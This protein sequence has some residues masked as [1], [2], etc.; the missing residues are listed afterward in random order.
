[1]MRVDHVGVR[2][3]PFFSFNDI[4]DT[5]TEP[6]TMYLAREFSQRGIAY[7]HIAEPGWV[8]GPALSDD[9]RRKLRAAYAGVLIC[10][11][12]YT[13]QSGEKLLA[14]GLADAIAFGR[15]FI[16]N[17]DL[18]ERICAGAALNVPDQTTFY[19]GGSAGYTDYPTLK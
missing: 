6:M 5:E 17:P 16:A 18:I 11:G 8:G 7:L 10:C 4:D 13:P 3:S 2:M 19:G 1:V 9:F 15:S 12:G 14:D